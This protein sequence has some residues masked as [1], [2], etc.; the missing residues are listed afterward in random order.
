M[1]LVC[2]SYLRM[3]DLIMNDYKKFM[4]FIDDPI[5]YWKY[6]KSG[7]CKHEW[8]TE[9]FIVG[10]QVN[11]AKTECRI[12]GKKCND[13]ISLNEFEGEIKGFSS[14]CSVHSGS[15]DECKY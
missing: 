7:V 15:D 3:G 2:G 12:C 8:R 5:E 10:Q 13:H 6:V 1:Y 11:E 9:K 14:C 4:S